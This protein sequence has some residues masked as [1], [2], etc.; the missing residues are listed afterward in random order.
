MTEYRHTYAAWGEAFYI[1]EKYE[2]GYGYVSA[3]HDI[4]YAGYKHVDEHD[5]KRLEELGWYYDADVECWYHH[6]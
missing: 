6:V 3:E 5:F 4:I 1:F 2:D